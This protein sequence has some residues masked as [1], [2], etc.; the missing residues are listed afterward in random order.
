MQKIQGNNNEKS[1]TGETRQEQ[2]RRLREK[3]IRK[4]I[5]DAAMEVIVS[6]GSDGFTM[7]R[8]AG[9]AGVA[10]GTLYLYFAGKTEV[11]QAAVDAVFEP[12]F[13]DMD[14]ILEEDTEPQGKLKRFFCCGLQFFQDNIQLFRILMYDRGALT[15]DRLEEGSHY[16]ICQDK[17]SQVLDE[18]VAKGV[19][20]SMNIPIVSNMIIEIISGQIFLNLIGRTNNTIDQQVEM[21]MDIV[22]HGIAPAKERMVL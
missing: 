22:M 6:K 5:L 16:W 8:L 2:R 14:S 7:D 1:H 11:I 12:L 17:I 10:K 3:G 4:C 13:R 15:D 19:F 9:D 21:I 18:G 20:H